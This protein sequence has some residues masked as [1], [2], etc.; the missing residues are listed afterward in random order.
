MTS[1]AEYWHVRSRTSSRCGWDDEDNRTPTVRS[2]ADAIM[3]QASAN[4]PERCGCDDEE[5]QHQRSV[6]LSNFFTHQE[7]QF[8]G[9]DR[10]DH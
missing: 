5:P 4:G 3:R 9:I 10:C 6:S 8:Y 7:D 2:D 1:T